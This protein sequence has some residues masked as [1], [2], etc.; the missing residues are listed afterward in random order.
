MNQRTD[1]ILIVDDD[2]ENRNM[3]SIIMK[4]DNYDVDT[5]VDGRHALEKIKKVKY[6]LLLLDLMMPVIDGYQML[7]VMQ[8]D[9]DT[10]AIPVIVITAVGKRESVRHCIAL[11]AKD[12]IIKPF[13]QEI[14]RS[15]VRSTLAS[16][17]LQRI[18]MSLTEA[19]KARKQEFS[20]LANEIIP[21]SMALF[22]ERDL[23]HVMEVAL[24]NAMSIFRTDAVVIYMLS[25]DNRLKIEAAHNRP[26][27]SYF[28]GISGNTFTYPAIEIESEYAQNQ[29]NDEVA[30]AYAAF[31]GQQISIDINDPQSKR[32]PPPLRL[33][34]DTDDFRALTH[35]I[36][37]LKVPS[38]RIIGI[39][40][41]INPRNPGRNFVSPFSEQ[42]E[43]M[44]KAFC[45]MLAVAVEVG[46]SMG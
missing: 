36:T 24:K 43:V 28:G 19:E 5:A 21:N 7:K 26:L 23:N 12:Y 15:R 1:R 40:E 44:A 37:P 3:L 45:H 8:S 17:Q 29:P 32:Q 41:L 9:P 33:F 46:K 18:Q 16:D 6:S 31:T 20:W 13:D 14:V 30:V 35:L 42:Q 2:E 25:E 27:D 39:L 10:Q 11:G 38:G 4:L 22:Y 34:G